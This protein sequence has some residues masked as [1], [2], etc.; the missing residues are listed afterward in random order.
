MSSLNRLLYRNW[1]SATF[2]C[3]Y[4]LLTLW[5]VPTMPR[6]TKAYKVSCFTLSVRAPQRC[7]CDGQ[8]R[9][10]SLCQRR[11]DPVFRPA[12]PS[13]GSWLAADESFVNFDNA[14][15]LGFGF[16]QGGADFVSHQPSG[17]DR[18]KTHIAAKLASA[19]SLLLVRIRWAIL[20]QSRS[21]LLAFSKIVPAKWEN[22]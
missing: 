14:A 13:G 21:G 8:R 7:P 5:K 4:F 10:Q 16:D 11:S 12:Y 9:Q 20:N 2:R 15:K 3:M 18:T 19:H 22:R 6:L 17:F 1:N